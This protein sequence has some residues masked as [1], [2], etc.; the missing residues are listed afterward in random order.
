MDRRSLACSGVRARRYGGEDD[1]ACLDMTSC[2]GARVCKDSL[3]YP[4]F[5][6]IFSSFQNRRPKL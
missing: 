3:T 4:F 5:T 2:A 6:R 1:M